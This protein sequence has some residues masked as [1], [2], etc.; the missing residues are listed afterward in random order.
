MVKRWLIDGSGMSQ[1]KRFFKIF[2]KLLISG[3]DIKYG[4]EIL[5]KR[6]GDCFKGTRGFLEMVHGRLRDD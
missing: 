5:K 6:F 2:L 4:S 3:L 1:G